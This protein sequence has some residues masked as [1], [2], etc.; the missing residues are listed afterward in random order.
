VQ[1]ADLK[2]PSA[3]V[4]PREVLAISLFEGG[5]LRDGRLPLARRCRAGRR[6]CRGRV[7]PQQGQG[8]LTGLAPR[9]E[10]AAVLGQELFLLPSQKLSD[11]PAVGPP[12][13]CQFLLCH[14]LGAERRAKGLC[15]CFQRDALFKGLGIER[16]HVGGRRFVATRED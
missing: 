8:R 1:G 2:T 13:V 14:V 5:R 11:A 16:T 6:A 9:P 3:K 10:P 12:E 7:G 4:L 15:L